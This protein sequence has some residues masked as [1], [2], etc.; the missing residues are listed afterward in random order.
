MTTILHA[1]AN[2]PRPLGSLAFL[3]LRLLN[4]L[5]LKLSAWTLTLAGACVL[6]LGASG[7][8][9]PHD[10]RYLGMTAA[11]L[12]ALHGCRIV[13]FMIHDRIS[14]GG[15]ALAV[16]RGYVWLVTSPLRQGQAWAWWTLVLSGV[17]GFASFLA[18]LGYGYL[19]SWHGLV[20]LGLL[21]TFGIGLAQTH[22]QVVSRKTIAWP[23]LGQAILLATAAGI[24]AAGAT[25]MVVGMTCVFVPQDLEFMGLDVAEMNAANPRLVSL[26]AHDRAGF[27]GGVCACGIAA[28]RLRLARHAFARALVGARVRRYRRVRRRHQ[29]IRPP[30]TSIPSTWR[31]RCSV[32]S[33]MRSAWH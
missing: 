14:F 33:P 10:E 19:D 25:I 2:E 7:Q 27:G 32:L 30:A 1:G 3:R 5:L 8:F 11:E 26:I 16:G 21:P 12:C 23:R 20:T 24:I 18:Y 4:S 6:V 29:R 13:H 31:P 28:L 9:L 22:R 15:A 17:V